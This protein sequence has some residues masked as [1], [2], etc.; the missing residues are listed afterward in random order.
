MF[1]VYMKIFFK[2]VKSFA[3]VG[4]EGRLGFLPDQDSL[5]VVLNL[6]A[7]YPSGSNNWVRDGFPTPF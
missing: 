6:Y 7:R 2:Y 5:A 1:Q 4:G 3:N